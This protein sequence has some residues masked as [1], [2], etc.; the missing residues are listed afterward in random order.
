MPGHEAGWL[1]CNCIKGSQRLW[2]FLGGL[3]MSGSPLVHV[4]VRHYTHE[5]IFK[6]CY[7]LNTSL[8]HTDTALVQ[9]T[10][11]GL[12]QA[13]LNYIHEKVF[14]CLMCTQPLS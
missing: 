14:T 7:Y 8:H 6:T 10:S 3:H 13:P 4:Q 9:L 5:R 11:M 2:N 12:A 1:H